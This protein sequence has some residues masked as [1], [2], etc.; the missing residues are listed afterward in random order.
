MLGDT[1]KIAKVV[2]GLKTTGIDGCI[3]GSSMTGMDFDDWQ[4]MPDVDVFVYHE[5]QLPYAVD[6]LMMMHGY[7]PLS[8]GEAWKIERLRNHR[9]QR[10]NAKALL[11]VKLVKDGV[12]V[13]ITYKEGKENLL[14]VLASF[15]MS[16]VMVGYDIRKR[17]LMDLRVGWPGMIGEDEEGR[18]SESEKVAV[19]NPLRNQDV[20]IYGASMWVRQFDRVIKYWDRGFDTRRMAEFYI[21]LIDRVIETGRLF[22]TERSDAAFQAFKD[23]FEP[24]K[25]KMQAWLAAK[26]D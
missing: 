7:E 9:T 8:K 22:A 19:P 24:I 3:T 18:W 1:D 6:L 26:E 5:P 21:G 4:T 10:R 17:V 14:S 23:E 12:V 13:N 2:A 16:I 11:T 20:D 25:G 15:D